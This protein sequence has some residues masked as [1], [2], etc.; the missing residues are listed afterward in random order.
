MSEGR[1]LPE[2]IANAHPALAMRVEL[3][4][5]FAGLCPM[6]SEPQEG[7]TIAVSYDAGTTLLETKALRR[8]LE[9]FAGE[10]PHSVRDLEEAAQ[11]IALDCAAALGVAV[12]V[13]ADYFLAIGA[14]RVVVSSPA[15]VFSTAD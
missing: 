2:V 11:R 3:R 10:N 9:S 1:P 6:S 4:Y 13:T 14:M 12:T 15:S 8:Y 7:S 5:P